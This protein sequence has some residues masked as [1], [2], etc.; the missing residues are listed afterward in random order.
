M[1]AVFTNTGIVRTGYFCRTLAGSRYGTIYPNRDLFSWPPD[2]RR[3]SLRDDL[4]NS[5]PIS[6]GRPDALRGSRH[7]TISQNR[8]LFFLAARTRSAE[9]VTSKPYQ[10][11]SDYFSVKTST[12]Y[13]FSMNPAPVPRPP[14]QSLVGPGLRCIEPVPLGASWR[15][16]L[17]SAGDLGGSWKPCTPSALIS[18]PRPTRD[19]HFHSL[20]RKHFHSLI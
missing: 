7:G 2:A 12:Y 5:G 17:Q 9:A 20:I 14:R 8:D 6:P 13:I 10:Y 11:L 15:Q 1:I 4:P 19:C 16:P 18:V 3:K